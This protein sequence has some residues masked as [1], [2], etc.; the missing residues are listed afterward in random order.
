MQPVALVLLAVYIATALILA[1]RELSFIRSV[2]QP[3]RRQF[4]VQDILLQICIL[5]ILVPSAT[6]NHLTPVLMSVVMGGFTL[7]WLVAVWMAV[8]RQRYIN[9][10]LEESRREG[11]RLMAELS[12]RIREEQAKEESGD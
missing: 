1:P 5:A 10:I 2:E 4:I 7:L 8:A 3:L 9:R 11:E 12:R 6:V